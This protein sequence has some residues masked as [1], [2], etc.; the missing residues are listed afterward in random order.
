M[1]RASRFGCRGTDHVKPLRRRIDQWST[2]EFPRPARLQRIRGAS[3]APRSELMRARGAAGRVGDVGRGSR[4]RPTRTAGEDLL[5]DEAPAPTFEEAAR[6]WVAAYA[7]LGQ[8]RV[9]TQALYLSALEHYAFPRFGSKPVTTVSRDDIRGLVVHLLGQ[10]R[11]QSLVRNVVAPIRQTFN[12]LIEDGAIAMNPAAKIGRF[13][14]DGGDPR[15]R[16]DPFTVE[17]EA[18]FLDTAHEHFPRHYSMLLCALRTGLRF[19][20]LVGLQW[21]DLDF[22]GRFV[23]VRRSLTTAGGSSCP[24]TRRFGASTC[25]ASSRRN[26]S[27]SRP[28]GRVRLSRKDGDRSPSGFSAMKM[29][30]RS[31]NQTSSGA[32]STRF[33]R[34]PGCIRFHDL[35][36]TFA[37]RLL[38]NGESPAYVKEQMG[39]HSIKVTVDIYPSGAGIEP[40]GVR[41]ARRNW[42]QPAEPMPR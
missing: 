28:R 38:E 29:A 14:R 10:G 39:H 11:S 31:G 22:K 18:L 40:G 16:I 37:S 5:L 19:G 34:G 25:P 33:S 4:S 6:S 1:G 35:R 12:Q 42:P 26:F 13:L 8:L 9:S 21:G 32:C 41:S 20:E 7:Q 15:A 36:H 24:R 2:P 3:R 27:G 23:D 30:S 17:E